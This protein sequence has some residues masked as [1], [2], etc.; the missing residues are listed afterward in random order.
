[1]EKLKVVC[2]AQI[3]EEYRNKLDARFDMKYTGWAVKDGW[4]LNEEECVEAFRDAD[5]L[6]VG[7]DH[8]TREVLDKC[9]NVKMISCPRGNPVNIDVKAAAERGIPVSFTPGR[10]ANSVAEFLLGAVIGFTRYIP[11]SYHEVRNGRFLAP[12]S[13]DIYRVPEKDDIVWGFA[14]TPPETPF[15][16]YYGY[17]LYR[18]RFGMIGYGAVGR[19]L[20]RFLQALEMEV[21]IYDPYLDPAVAEADG[22]KM[23]SMDEVISTS[24]FVS[25]HCKVTPE[26]KGMFGKREFELMRPDA[27]FINTAR[28]VIVDQKALIDALEQKKIRG[29]VIDVFWQ[30]P[31]PANHPLLKMDNVVMTPHIAGASNDVARHQSVMVY[32]DIEAFVEGRP[33]KY[34]FRVK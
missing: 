34:Q 2:T 16:A 33:L 15:M 21:V 23:L 19:R 1:M 3:T 8:V 9:P 28:G 18:R 27:V 25:L 7:V 13:R 24:E 32:E 20:N 26:T 17:E 14:M 30:E 4:I 6:I 22:V 11:L 12:A 31:M 5:I 29:A 10:N